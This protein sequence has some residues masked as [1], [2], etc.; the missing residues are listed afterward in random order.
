MNDTYVSRKSG[1]EAMPERSQ[2]RTGR[3][4]WLVA[5]VGVVVVLVILG[6]IKAGQIGSMIKAG[7]ALVPPP[8][9]VQSA[10]VRA[11][12]WE[13][14]RAAIGTLVAVR[15]VTVGAELPGTIREIAF[16]S[17][18][19]VRRGALLVRLDTSTEEAQL[20]GALADAAL[21]R[22]NLARA[23]SLRE[24]EANAPADVDVAEAR[25]KQ[26]E[27]AVANL[28]AT[29]AKKAIRAPFDGRVAIRQVEL[30]Q[31]VQSGAP[32]ASIQSVSPIYAEF[33]L[34]QLALAE[35]KA[36]E[37]ARV[38]TDTFPGAQWD[39]AVTTINPEVDPATRNVRIRASFQNLDGRL[40]PGMF[41]N[42]QVLSSR[43]ESRIV[44]PATAV[45]FAPYGD[46]VFLIEERKGA[47]GKAATAVRQQ[48]VRL[49]ER[50]GDFVAV[51][52]GLE[53]GKTIVSSGA[54]K[55]RQGSAV[56]VNDASPLD[57]ELAPRPS[58]Q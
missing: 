16:D 25:G 27:A 54:F 41:V 8:E 48:F 36:G 23:R 40:R 28:K 55:L 39:G 14:A 38:T 11:V 6:G 15:G 7:K 50:R 19:S 56:V 30:G 18:A 37:S 52:A 24:G 57:A 46:S 43:K 32:I 53:A 33:W 4:A 22:A 10:K 20:E 3:R 9:S 47:D 17:G 49:G 51:T 45:I 29:I 35:L 13:T 42:V 1:T 21:A 2:R 34:P 44:I 5:S 31:A 26:A 12:E 58:E